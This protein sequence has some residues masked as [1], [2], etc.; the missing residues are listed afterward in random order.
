MAILENEFQK[1]QANNEIFSLLL[2]DIDNF[3]FVNDNYGFSIGDQVLKEISQFLVNYLEN[4]GTVGRLGDEEFMII[5]PVTELGAVELA[6]RLCE[7]IRN[8]EI[9]TTSGPIKITISIGMTVYQ[10]DDKN[11]TVMLKRAYNLLYQAKEQS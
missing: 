8:L 5:L 3:K 9:D 4:A 7:Q 10:P 11:Y 6:E 2:I 1:T